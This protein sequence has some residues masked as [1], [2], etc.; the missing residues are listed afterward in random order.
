MPLPCL[1]YVPREALTYYLAYLRTY[2]GPYLLPCL[3]V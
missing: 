2:A 1:A 3:P